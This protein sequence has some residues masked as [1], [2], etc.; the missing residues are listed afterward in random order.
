MLR[1]RTIQ[2][3]RA[4]RGAAR[5]A[6]ALRAGALGIALALF[7]LLAPVAGATPPTHPPVPALDLVGAAPD[8]GLAH[9]AQPFNH[10]CGTGVDSHGDVYVASAGNGEID[11]FNAAHEFLVAIPDAHEPCGLA[12]NGA[13]E[14]FVSEQAEGTVVRYRPSAYPF[15]GTPTYGAAETIDSSGEARGISV[16]PFDGR[17]YVAE[18]TRVAAYNP[19]GSLGIDEVDGIAGE[20]TAGSF[21]LV[22][23]GQERPRFPATRMPRKSK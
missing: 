3:T 19:D 4:A 18:G 14:L 11:V 10:A 23:E 13:G 6:P 5:V 1:Q 20:C 15:V 2:R 12:V 22:F 21:K 16:D 17:L 7:G 8:P 9:P